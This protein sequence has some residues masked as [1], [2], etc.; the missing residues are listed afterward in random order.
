MHVESLAAA[1]VHR[2]FGIPRHDL[3]IRRAVVV[4]VV[5]HRTERRLSE[6]I[7][8][9]LEFA[10]VY[11][12]S[13]LGDLQGIGTCGNTPVESRD[14]ELSIVHPIVRIGTLRKRTRLDGI[15]A[16]HQLELSTFKFAIALDNDADG[17]VGVVAD[18]VVVEEGIGPGAACS[19]GQHEWYGE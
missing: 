7:F 11:R 14:V 18:L 10:R 13:V 1:L 17:L 12:L 4:E 2:K 3:R 15:A 9:H 8:G 19:E 5:E 6:S 16:R